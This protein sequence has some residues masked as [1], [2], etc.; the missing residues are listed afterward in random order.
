MLAWHAWIGS[1]HAS[2]QSGS[3]QQAQHA[4][5]PQLTCALLWRTGQRS[6][7]H[8]GWLCP[9]RCRA[10]KSKHRWAAPQTTS[11]TA[12]SAGTAGYLQCACIYLCMPAM[13]GMV[14]GDGTHRR[15]AQRRASPLHQVCLLLERLQP[16]MSSAQ[17]LA[18]QAVHKLLI[19]RHTSITWASVSSIPQVAATQAMG[20][21][22][23]VYLCS[24]TELS[25]VMPSTRCAVSWC[26]CQD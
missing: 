17:P 9:T 10:M 2:F 8:A 14:L 21:T 7:L 18:V 3:R 1:T 12:P 25:F 5:V 26:V 19:R 23:K 24:E 6:S 15:P 4:P 11:A 16:H 22:A 13:A 20:R